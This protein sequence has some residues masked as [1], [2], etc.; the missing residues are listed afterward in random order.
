MLKIRRTM[1]VSIIMLLCS[2]MAATAAPPT[3]TLEGLIAEALARNPEIRGGEAKWQMLVAKA[4]R[5][6]AF[7]DPMLMIGIQNGMVSDPLAFDSDPMTSKMIGISQMLPFYGKRALMRAEAES[8]AEASRWELEERKVQ[9]R[10]MISETWARLAFVETSL[11]LVEKNLG[12]LDEIARLAEASYK[13]GMGNQG[14]ILR[15]Q[16]E[17]SRMEEMK[18]GL[19]QQRSSL[20]AMFTALLRRDQSADIAVPEG[21]LEPVTATAPELMALALKS[22]P[23]I[24]AQRARIDMAKASKGLARREYFPDFT[25][26]LEY[27]QRDA[28][29]SGMATSD[30]EDMYNA[31]LSFNLPVLTAKRR[32]MVA[33]AHEAQQMAEADVDMLRNEIRRDIDDLLAKLA[34]SARMERLYREALLPQDVFAK[35]SILAAYRAGQVEFM[36]VLDAQMKLI[37]DEQK[38]AMFIAEHQMLRAQLEATL[39]TKLP[40]PEQ[41]GTL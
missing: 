1:W 2:G 25:L 21:V 6:G 5:T 24:N 40:A 37:N 16:I 17:S 15:V 12:L 39:G 3:E 13:S 34:A 29:T 38:Q 26:T 7:E 28:F 23:E 36:S 9:M 27:M 33:E 11:R 30:G 35:E 10:K 8:D 31:K 41:T 32:A 19:Q 14:D 18:I 22:R 20:Q 4:N